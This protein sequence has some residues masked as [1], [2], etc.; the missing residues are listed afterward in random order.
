V[1]VGTIR[2]AVGELEAENVLV[3]QQGRGTFVAS[4]TR[5]Y[6]LNVFFRIEG[7]DGRK[8]LP[9]ATLLSMRRGR[10]DRLTAKALELGARAPVIE[11]ET[12]LRLHGKP[13]ILDRAWLP[14]YLFPQLD[15]HQFLERDGTVYGMFQ[16]RFGIT[17]VR[18][19]EYLTAV[20]ADALAVRLLAVPPGA[21]L[22]RIE[23]TAYSYKD[24][25]VDF[26]IRLIDCREHGYMSLL[27][28]G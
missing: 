15:E 10:A 3:R 19:A 17:V 9:T 13:T 16:Q 14:A 23:R 1:S 28:K 20:T 21:P 27:G 12:L 26:R 22:L 5:D 18:I 11:I 4:H 8:E 6:M 25:P 2:K 7:R 24:Q